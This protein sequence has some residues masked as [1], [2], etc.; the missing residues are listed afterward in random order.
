M[1]H[2]APW[3][4]MAL[5]PAAL[6]RPGML[7][8][9]CKSCANANMVYNA[10]AEMRAGDGSLIGQL[11]LLQSIPRDQA[12]NTVKGPVMVDTVDNRDRLEGLKTFSYSVQLQKGSCDNLGEVVASQYCSNCA[13]SLGVA[14][15]RTRRE[16]RWCS[17]ASPTPTASCSSTPRSTSPSSAAGRSGM[18]M[19]T[20]RDKFLTQ[21]Y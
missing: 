13:N 4:V 7:T 15:S 12:D 1:R 20:L 10:E 9:V 5:P 17:A 19:S 3:L 16:R 2:L 21:F 18:E 11:R 14:R 8:W 6:G